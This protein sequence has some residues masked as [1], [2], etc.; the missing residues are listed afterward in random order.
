M[1]KIDSSN[2]N[3]CSG[4]TGCMNIC[5]HDSI[6][7]PIDNEGF[8]Y[9]IVNLETCTDCK[10]CEDVCPVISTAAISKASEY[11][12][13][14]CNYNDQQVQLASSSGGAFTAIADYVLK[15][16]GVVYGAA[17]SAKD[18]VT[19][20]KVDE[21]VRIQKL[22]GSKYI[23]SKL[24]YT[25]TEIRKILRS[26]Q[27][28][29]FTG[30][31]CQVAGL[32]TFLRRK[33]ENL[34]TCDFICFGVGSP[35]L[36]TKYIEHLEHKYNLEVASYNFRSKN[37]GWKD[38]G[39]TGS[40]VKFTDGTIREITPIYNNSY[41]LGYSNATILRPICYE[42]PFKLDNNN[43]SD[44][45]LADFWGVKKVA[46]NAYSD[47]GT[48]MLF[49]NTPVAKQIFSSINHNL[50]YEAVDINDVLVYQPMLNKSKPKPEN[51]NQLM[52]NLDQL[53]YSQIERKFMNKYKWIGTKVIERGTRLIF[54]GK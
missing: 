37:A 24:D 52:E 40:S 15:Q 20:I 54:K 19:H 21:K 22:R 47:K 26:G 30:T 2:L 4:C 36:F 34:I 46:P 18:E 38:Y 53:T 39:Q 23:Q 51:R 45:K 27:L 43:V 35:K 33:Y 5:G 28:V 12:L 10:L 13:Y 32:L 14:A 25:F 31:P 16:N 44:F 17:Y 42:C 1:I 7:M 6:S 41:M 50:S 29:L 49:V 9:P 11:D 48:S 8:A 3:E